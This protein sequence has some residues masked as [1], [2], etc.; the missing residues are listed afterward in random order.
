MYPVNKPKRVISTKEILFLVAFFGTIL[1]LLH[2][3]DLFQRLL[4]S[5]QSN[6]DLTEAYLRNLVR[7]KP[8]DTKTLYEFAKVLIH[9]GKYDLAKTMLSAL[10]SS[11]KGDIRQKAVYLRYKLLKQELGV[12]K[13]PR[14]KRDILNALHQVL[15]RIVQKEHSPQAL[16]KWLKESKELGDEKIAFLLLKRIAKSRDGDI[17]IIEKTY[18]EALNRHDLKTAQWAMQQ[19]YR[20][21]KKWLGDYTKDPKGFRS[22][23]RI[24]VAEL[25]KARQNA[26]AAGLMVELYGQSKARQDLFDALDY[27][28]WGGHYKEAVTL[29]KRFEKILTRDKTGAKK[30]I[31]LYLAAG[32]TDDARRLSLQLLK[33]VYR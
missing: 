17:G 22:K 32:R 31:E 13:S 3:K 15:L 1:G 21:R 26:K 14:Q 33:R 5:E 8:D 2:S 19:L 16:Q 18:Y 4:L 9:Q 7:L 23:T 27:L 20:Q 6:Y 28:M 10:E 29:A 12:T 25:L 30:I 24:L 11:K